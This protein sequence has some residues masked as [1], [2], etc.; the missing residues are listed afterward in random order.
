MEEYIMKIK[1]F[2]GFKPDLTCKGFKFIPGVE[3]SMDED[4]INLCSRGFHSCIIPIQCYSY[5]KPLSGVFHEVDIDGGM[6][7]SKTNSKI[8]SCKITV[9]EHELTA[10]EII[11]RTYDCIEM[12]IENNDQY[13]GTI[14]E[15]LA[16]QIKNSSEEGSIAI[17]DAYRTIAASNVEDDLDNGTVIN[18]GAKS[19]AASVGNGKYVAV[20]ESNTIAASV[21]KSNTVVSAGS[22]SVVS[23]IGDYN[24]V[25][26]EEQGVIAVS[27]GE[28][29]KVIAEK[30]GSMVIVAG[31]DSIGK[32]VLNSYLVFVDATENESGTSINKVVTIFIDGTKYKPN[33][34]YKLDNGIVKSA[35]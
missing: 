8:V 23:S 35:V 31:K 25:S 6:E 24:F 1:S 32:G 28:Q 2:K 16:N 11:E 13:Q 17:S 3:Y 27:I 21:G 34:W 10:K 26:A 29:C 5:Y 9:D 20:S 18:T 33:T 7:M 15:D 22:K 14:I 30:A 4:K 19:I 12:M